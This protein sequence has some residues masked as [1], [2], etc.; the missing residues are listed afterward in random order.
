M[1][2]VSIRKKGYLH[3]LPVK[4]IVKVSGEVFLVL[5]NVI[6]NINSLCS[7]KFLQSVLPLLLFFAEV[8]QAMVC[9]AQHHN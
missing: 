7:H 6:L 4:G 2:L 1:S 8:E 5:G 9:I 3:K